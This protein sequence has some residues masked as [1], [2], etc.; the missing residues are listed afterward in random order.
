MRRLVCIAFDLALACSSA[1]LV[2][3][4]PIAVHA[5]TQVGGLPVTNERVKALEDAIATLQAKVAAEI[6]ARQSLATSL[7]A[8]TAARQAADAALQSAI[9]NIQTGVANAINSEIAARQ[10]ADASLQNA[11]N[12]SQTSITAI[13]TKIAQGPK[14]VVRLHSNFNNGVSDPTN[15]AIVSCA[16][17][18]KLT[19]GGAF[20][21]GRPLLASSPQRTAEPLVGIS[22]GDEPRAWFAE[23]TSPIPVDATIYTFAVCLQP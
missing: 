18:E 5:Q 8:E 20:S 10:A 3:S 19:G 23:N 14:T 15:T 21:N 2:L 13:Q 6:S 16:P 4:I 9:S 17:G 12:N 1:V 7:A 11:I 22:D